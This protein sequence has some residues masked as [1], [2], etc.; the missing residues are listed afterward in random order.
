[1]RVAG[2]L[3]LPIVLAM[4]FCATSTQ[5]AEEV[6]PKPDEGNAIRLRVDAGLDLSVFQAT[7][8]AA[9]GYGG[10]YGYGVGPHLRVGAQL[11][12]WLAVYYQAEL[13]L[14]ANDT[15]LNKALWNSA[16]I[17][18]TFKLFQLALGPSVDVLTIGVPIPMCPA[19]CGATTG[20]NVASAFL[21]GDGHIGVAI[22][23]RGPG[24]HIGFAAS[25]NGHLDF[26]SGGVLMAVS[27]SLG[28]EWY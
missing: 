12:P 23:D 3:S 4:A 10:I 24:H 11:K 20:A 21:G 5:A 8:G 17:E 19:P 15:V 7:S 22:R 16:E 14:P 18:G 13:L 2:P 1:M 25:L 6:T 26:L 28:V 27:Q 9:G